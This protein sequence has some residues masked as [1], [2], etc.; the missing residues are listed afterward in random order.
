MSLSLLINF[1]DNCDKIDQQ[2]CADFLLICFSAQNEIEE[3]CGSKETL[4]ILKEHMN[5]I[6]NL[7]K[8]ILDLQ[9][10]HASSLHRMEARDLSIY[11]RV[12]PGDVRIPSPMQ[13]PGFGSRV[14]MLGYSVR[15][16]TGSVTDANAS[17]HDISI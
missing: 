9:D 13:D 12:I 6:L 1:A 2:L 10:K 15:I 5:F 8:G 7:T 16:Y 4:K 3:R 14:V 11:L 17:F